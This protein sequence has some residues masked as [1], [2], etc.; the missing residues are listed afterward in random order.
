MTLNEKIQK[1]LI[2]SSDKIKINTK[3]IKKNDVF[4]ALQGT[5]IHGNEFIYEALNVGA[6][7]VITDKKFSQ[8]S[9]NKQI[10]LVENTFIFIEELSIK[11]RSLYHGEVI[12]I[13]GSAG[14][15]SLKENLKFFLDKKEV[16][17]L[18]IGLYGE[19]YSQ[20]L[21]FC[22]I[23]NNDYVLADIDGVVIIPQN[24]IEDI[25]NRSEKL[26]NT[27]NLVRKSIKEGMDPQEAYLKY[28]AF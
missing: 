12:G 23:N 3:D 7:Y 18:P 2:N 21:S 20:E 5:N 28:S 19:F 1:Y 4:I 6:K 26:I 16:T 9:F 25:L 17:N 11:K 13:T 24:N 15:T 27:E 22:L 10:L 14:K 8:I